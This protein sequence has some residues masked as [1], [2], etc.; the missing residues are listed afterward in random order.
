MTSTQATLDKV[1]VRLENIGGIGESTVGFSP[2]VTVLVGRNATNRTSLLR[3]IMIALGSDEVSLKGD[4]DQGKVELTVGGE[5][6]TRHLMRR[7]GTIVAEGDPLLDDPTLPDL[8]AFLLESNEARRAVSRGEDLRDLIMRPVDTDAIE[9]ELDRRVS[10]R[11]QLED[12]LSELQSLKDKLPKLEEERDHLR[13]QIEETK[14]ELESKEQEIESFDFDVEKTRDEKTE[15]E[16]QLEELREKRSKLGDIRYDLNTERESLESFRSERE[17]FEDEL[18]TLPETPSSEIEEVDTRLRRLRNRKQELETEISSIQNVVSFNEDLVAGGS[19]EVFDALE[20]DGTDEER[21]TDR[22]LDDDGVTCWTCGSEVAT[23]QIETTLD[24]LRKLSQ[25]KISQLNDIDEDISEL[26]RER[27]ELEKSQHRRDEINRQL[28][29]LDRKISDSKDS[30]ERLQESQES[31]NEEIET[32][33]EEI[34][35]VDDTDYDGVLELHRN[36]NQLEYELGRLETEFDRVEENIASVEDRLAR[37]DDIESDLEEIENEI[38]DLRTRIEQ[39]EQSA[40]EQF[41]DHMDAVL[42]LLA[43][44]NLDRIWLERVQEEVREGRRKVS[45]NTFKL[46]VVRTAT[47]GTVYEDTVDHLS[48]SEREVIG[49]VFALAGYLAH[50]V[51]EQVPFMILD[52]L[53]AIDAGRIA[54]LIEYLEEYTSYLLVALLPEDASALPEAYERIT[55]I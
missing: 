52:S 8:F 7:S 5:T 46:H 41:N 38:E 44:D 18:D 31:L 47:G 50:D 45:K 4:A 17:E 43:Y 6:Y 1:S 27:R 2:G 29:Q 55:N 32:I 12:E 49:L 36:A 37:E 19:S 10:E 33:E 9:T 28:D 14:S 24:H 54:A 22:L 15:H 51:Y 40:I 42:D 53:E 30:I 13:D 25:R 26:E 11:Q 3:G 48:E 20:S 21:T 34:E 16:E 23:E 35:E 39:I